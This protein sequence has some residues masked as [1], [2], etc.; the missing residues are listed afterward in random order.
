M[1]TCPQLSLP[2]FYPNIAPSEE[3]PYE[4][5]VLVD[6]AVLHL[7]P[8]RTPVSSTA[9]GMLATTS[10]IS[11]SET[12][13]QLVKHFPATTSCNRSRGAA[14]RAA[15]QQGQWWTW[16]SWGRRLGLDPR[17]PCT[18]GGPAAISFPVQM[19][20]SV[21]C[22][23]RPGVSQLGYRLP[24]ESQE[25]SA[26]ELVL[27]PEHPPLCEKVLLVHHQRAT[28]LTFHTAVTNV[29]LQLPC[30]HPRGL[31]QPPPCLCLSQSLLSER[32]ELLFP[33]LLIIINLINKET[34]TKSVKS[35]SCSVN[36][37]FHQRGHGQQGETQLRC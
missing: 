37:P 2:C 35:V 32:K 13:M 27:L 19:G 23:F 34:G 25:L 6:S 29:C 18:P 12:D 15:C 7:F 10:E 26:V 33:M 28:N 17:R 14:L 11:A 36:C 21:P 24:K 3:L 31:G 5:T 16:H 8:Q 30:S 20:H 4:L 1:E 22:A 9:L